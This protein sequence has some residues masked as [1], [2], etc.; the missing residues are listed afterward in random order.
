MT[1]TGI[2][3]IFLRRCNVKRQPQR[4]VLTII[5][6]DLGL[7]SLLLKWLALLDKYIGSRCPTVTTAVPTTSTCSALVDVSV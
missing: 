2:E 4:S 6:Q 1:P 7:S 5:L 3:P